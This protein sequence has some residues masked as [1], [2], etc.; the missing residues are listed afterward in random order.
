MKSIWAHMIGMWLTMPSAD[1]RTEK[2][3]VIVVTLR[4]RVAARINQLEKAW[5]FDNMKWYTIS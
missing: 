2:H 4:L 5:I 3:N 1:R